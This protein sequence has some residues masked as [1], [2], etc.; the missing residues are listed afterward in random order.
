MLETLLFN[1]RVR[2]NEPG[3]Q[4][5]VAGD[6]QLGYYG[7]VEAADFISGTDLAAMVGL[8]AGTVIANTGQW[9][10]FAYKGKRLYIAKQPFRNFISGNHLADVNI[11]SGNRQVNILNRSFAVR[12]VRGGSVTPGAGS[13]WNDLLYRVHASDPT[14][15]FWERFTNE[16]LVVGVG[17]GRTT[18]CM[19]VP[20]AARVYR[21]YGSLTEWATGGLGSTS[22]TTGWRPVLELVS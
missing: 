15:T 14:G 10:K 5:L 6:D 21:G 7:I 9:L 16:E 19:E 22:A 20:T 2:A 17:N 4:K 12:L 11:V 18:W 13:E 8:N 3:P 1:N